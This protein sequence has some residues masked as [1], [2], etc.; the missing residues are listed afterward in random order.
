MAK[1][2]KLPTP[3]KG[4]VDTYFIAGDW[5]DEYCH[6]PTVEIMLQMARLI[7]RKNRKLIINGDFIDL[8]PFMSSVLSKFSPETIKGRIDSYY[9]PEINKAWAWANDMLDKMERTF[10][11]IIFIDGNHDWRAQDFRDKYSPIA[12]KDNFDL[13]INLKLKERGIKHIDYNAWLDIGH[14]SITH[15][16]YHGASALKKHYEASGGRNV[17]YGHVHQANSVSF[18]RRDDTAMAWSMPCICELNPDYL[19]NKDNNWSN[20]FG[21][22]SMRSNGHFNFDVKLVWDRELVD[23]GKVYRG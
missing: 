9:I 15:G 11:E 1:V 7:P 13:E 2:T 8:H 14:V 10:D 4:S 18:I 12:Y 22:L 17:I 5:H 19:K 21:I 23:L 6:L 16:M 3:K 20:G